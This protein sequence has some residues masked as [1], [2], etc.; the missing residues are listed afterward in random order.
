MEPTADTRLPNQPDQNRVEQLLRDAHL[1]RMRQQ[2]SEAEALCRQA[3]LLS[4][5]DPMGLEM[6]GDLMAER[7]KIDEALDLYRQAFERQPGKI[8]L[9]EKIARMV[10]RK[11]EAERERAEALLL[12]NSPRRTE[13]KRNVTI[14]LLLSVVCPGAGQIFNGQYVKGGILLA[15]FLLSIFG[16]KDMLLMLLVLSGL[17]PGGRSTRGHAVGPSVQANGALVLLGVVG[18]GVYIYSLL[19]ASAQAG[20]IKKG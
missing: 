2:W 1:R 18:V 4:P 7:S 19:D 9:E 17:D 12:V 3:L 8:I 5:E 11:A 14:A 10:L 15:A 6:L 13:G 20:K 16:W